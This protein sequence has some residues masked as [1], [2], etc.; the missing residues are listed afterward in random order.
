MPKEWYGLKEVATLTGYSREYIRL[1]VVNAVIY[2]KSIL[3]IEDVKSIDVEGRS[4][5]F[6]NKKAISKFKRRAKKGFPK[7]AKR[8]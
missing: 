4:F 2:E 1:N 5:W 6:V 7:N 3:S 8:K